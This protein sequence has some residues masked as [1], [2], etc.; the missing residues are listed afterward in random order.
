M[1]RK[2]EQVKEHTQFS[3]RG[4]L[5]WSA[6]A[7]GAS[8][9]A[10]Y[11]AAQAQVRPAKAAYDAQVTGIRILPGQWRPHFPWEQIAWVSPPWASEDYLWL[12]FPEAIF[13][14]QEI[15]FLSHR[16]PEVETM[17]PDLPKA[18]WQPLPAG[19]SFER[20][21]P[22]GVT[23]GGKLEKRAEDTVA[24]E[25]YIRNGSSA[26]L[27]NITLQTCAYLRAILE[28]ADFTRENKFVHTPAQGWLPLARALELPDTEQPYRAGWRTKGKRVLDVPVVLTKSN[29]GERYI[30]FT[31]GKDTLSIIGNPHHP[32]MHADPKFADIPAGAEGRVHG[33]LS[34]VEGALE[35]FEPEKFLAD[36]G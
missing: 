8:G 22:N 11:A 9:F 13:I 10:R 19:M 32:C 23:F 34:F 1:T 2:D 20:I 21:L 7:A 16:T 17:F 33:K 25:L 31:W 28:F 27:T 15:L 12:D 6:G 14:G 29:A 35:A 26:P 24:L 18:P 3:R 36:L 30:A 4:F 5:C